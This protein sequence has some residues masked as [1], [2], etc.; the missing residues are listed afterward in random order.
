M[1]AHRCGLARHIDRAQARIGAGEDQRVQH[2]VGGH[3][4]QGGRLRVY[5]AEVRTL[6]NR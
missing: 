3:T 4:Q 6:A 2:M 5:H 1:R